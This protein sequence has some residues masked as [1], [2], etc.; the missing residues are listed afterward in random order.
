M[1]DNIHFALNKYPNGITS[2][3]YNTKIIISKI[4][5]LS[6][7]PPGSTEGYTLLTVKYYKAENNNDVV[8]TL[9]QYPLS[10]RRNKKSK[11]ILIISRVCLS[12]IA[13]RSLSIMMNLLVEEEGT[14]L[15]EI[16]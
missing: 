2:R 15:T 13:I 6:V 16:K 9:K 4:I 14:V 1:K 8:S 3:Y 5:D 10:K 12:L 7:L 11:H